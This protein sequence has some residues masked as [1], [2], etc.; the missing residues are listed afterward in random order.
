M[1]EAT[2]PTSEEDDPLLRIAD[3]AKNLNMTP[4]H[5]RRNL[6]APNGGTLPAIKVGRQYRVR[7][8]DLKEFIEQRYFISG[9][10]PAHA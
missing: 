10:R 6:L 4:E 2:L 7:R 1:T 3:V 9:T 5:V 8:S